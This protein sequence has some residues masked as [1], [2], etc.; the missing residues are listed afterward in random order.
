MLF[1]RASFLSWNI[2]MVSSVRLSVCH[3]IFSISK[4]SETIQSRHITHNYVC[5][6][7][8]ENNW[9]SRGYTP[10]SKYSRQIPMQITAVS[11]LLKAKTTLNTENYRHLNVTHHQ[12][13]GVTNQAF[14]RCT[15]NLQ[16]QF[17]Y[18]TRDIFFPVFQLSQGKPDFFSWGNICS[19]KCPFKE[20]LSLLFAGSVGA[21][22][23]RE[24]N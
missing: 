21:S 17:R 4:S 16:L 2:P 5:N 6:T 12:K 9:A 24:L 1:V 7:F 22:Q 20:N 14:K 3:Q 23:H 11:K 8:K 19:S 18:P 10:T 15:Q 13:S